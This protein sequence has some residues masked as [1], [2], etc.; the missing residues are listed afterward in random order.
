[1]KSR[2]KRPELLTIGWR[3]W[4]ALPDLGIDKIKAKVDTGARSSSLHAYDVRTFERDG[5]QMVRFKVHPVQRSTHWTCEA[6]A[7][8]VEF[9]HVKSSS[10]H[11]THRPVILTTVELLGRKFTTEITLANRDAMGFRMLL[12][13]QTLRNHFLV[14][15]GHSYVGGD[16]PDHG[17]EDS[18]K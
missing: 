17:R 6:T 18:E 5:V 13:R 8:V 2:K 14:D 16:H 3:E 15:S 1:M 11:Q 12:G 4:V 7:K 9:R 10:G